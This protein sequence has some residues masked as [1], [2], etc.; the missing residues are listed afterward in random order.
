MDTGILH[1][2]SDHI[3]VELGAFRGEN[4]GMGDRVLARGG[5]A[6]GGAS[7]FAPPG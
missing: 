6:F 2:K 3:T 1:A 4:Q 7:S 5:R